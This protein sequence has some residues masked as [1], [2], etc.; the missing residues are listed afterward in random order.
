[1]TAGTSDLDVARISYGSIAYVNAMESPK[2]KDVL[3]ILFLFGSFTDR[4]PAVRL[5]QA[6]DRS[7]FTRAAQ[8]TL[9][10]ETLYNGCTECT[11]CKT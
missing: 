8:M 10:M 6:T 3:K 7:P 4:V 2:K 9:E 5:L 11:S 1:M